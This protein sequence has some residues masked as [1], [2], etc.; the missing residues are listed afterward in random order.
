MIVG[1]VADNEIVE[2]DAVF[3]EI[4]ENGPNYRNV[5]P[6]EPWPSQVTIIS[7]CTNV[8]LSCRSDGL[9]PQA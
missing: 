8:F 9:A 3:G 5:S 7:S 4:R 6:R 1:S 2:H